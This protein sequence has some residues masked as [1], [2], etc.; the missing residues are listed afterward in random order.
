M[1][2]RS[3]Q[4]T[5][6]GMVVSSEGKTGCLVDRVRFLW[7]DQAWL[8]LEAWGGSDSVVV[9]LGIRVNGRSLVVDPLA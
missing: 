2:G 9:T 4:S 1:A 8:L 6:W 3:A 7:L 5:A